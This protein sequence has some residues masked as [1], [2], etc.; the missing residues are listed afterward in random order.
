M[1]N[2]KKYL[3]VL[4][5]ALT[6][7]T[8]W[9]SICFAQETIQ[10]PTSAEI[11]RDG[12]VTLPI[13]DAWADTKESGLEQGGWI[14]QNIKTGELKVARIPGGTSFM[15]EVPFPEPEGGWRAVGF[16]H[17][18]PPQ[19]PVD[20]RGNK[21]EGGPSKTDLDPKNSL[22]VPEWVRDQGNYW[23]FGPDRGIYQR[24][25]NIET[26]ETTTETTTPTTTFTPQNIPS[27]PISVTVDSV[28]YQLVD[29]WVQYWDG[30]D[31]RYEIY[32]YDIVASGTVSGPLYSTF[33]IDPVTFDFKVVSSWTYDELPW[34]G[35]R[36]TG[37]PEKTNWTATST[38]QINL[39]I[40]P[41]DNR[42]DFDGIEN[43]IEVVATVTFQGVG[44]EQVTVAKK[45]VTISHP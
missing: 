26:N 7:S 9:G 8:G 23:P 32:S 15:I 2:F 4:L 37:D 43:T 14:L 13:E 39:S 35:I 31:D 27:G 44:E 22:G 25:A 1:R 30:P 20:I 24:P 36:D 38:S 18:H 17:T 33:S 34:G 21:W 45:T 29:T 28:T 11:R 41:Q 40:R 5:C 16:F 12:N 3:L 42:N 19:P 10:P 6:V